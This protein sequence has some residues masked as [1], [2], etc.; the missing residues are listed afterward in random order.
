MAVTGMLPAPPPCCAAVIAWGQSGSRAS[1][2]VSGQSRITT[3]AGVTPGGR[4]GPE[5]SGYQQGSGTGSAGGRWGRVQLVSWPL[6][7]VPG[8]LAPWRLRKSDR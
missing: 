5:R 7:T 6:R 2:A 3:R 1:A 8:L 4:L